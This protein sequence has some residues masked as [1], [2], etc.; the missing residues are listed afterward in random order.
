MARSELQ[1]RLGKWMIAAGFVVT[2]LSI[3]A[4]C[5]TCFAAGNSAELGEILL[6][7][8]VPFARITLL[9]LGI[10]SAL[11]L[12]GSFTYLHGVMSADEQATTQLNGALHN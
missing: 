3:I 9:G 8:A 2:V 7:N 12:V 10:G 11:W 5:V 4:Y 6:A 1:Q